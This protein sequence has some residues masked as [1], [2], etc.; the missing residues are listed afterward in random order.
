MDYIVFNIEYLLTISGMMI[1][2][3]KKDPL[4]LVI[5]LLP[6]SIALPHSIIIPPSAGKL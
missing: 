4:R 1:H 2:S 6:S 5:Y 3:L